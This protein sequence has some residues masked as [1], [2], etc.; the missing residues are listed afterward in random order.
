MELWMFMQLH[1]TSFETGLCCAATTSC[2]EARSKGR[3]V[4]CW[5]EGKVTARNLP[6][7]TGDGFARFPCPWSRTVDLDHWVDVSWSCTVHQEPWETY[8]IVGRLFH[9]RIHCDQGGGGGG[10]YVYWGRQ[11][12]LCDRY[13]SYISEPL[14]I[15]SEYGDTSRSA[16]ELLVTTCRGYQLRGTPHTL[17]HAKV[18]ISKLKS[19][20]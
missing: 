13:L 2:G 18:S 3:L 15:E 1:G 12:C 8:R 7:C 17:N 9:R 11:E 19:I 20:K 4:C 16:A 6:W 14:I 10:R 5:A